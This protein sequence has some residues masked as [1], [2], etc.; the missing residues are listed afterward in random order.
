[1]LLIDSGDYD[2]ANVVVTVD[3]GYVGQ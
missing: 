3:Q 2:V 1:M